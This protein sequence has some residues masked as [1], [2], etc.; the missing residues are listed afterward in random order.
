MRSRHAGLLQEIRT[1]GV[2]TASTTSF[3]HSKTRSLQPVRYR[4]AD[5]TAVD[6]DEVGDA[7]SDKT[8]ATE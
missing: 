7:N 5:P 1:S 4:N 2:L 6:A 3:N 8:L